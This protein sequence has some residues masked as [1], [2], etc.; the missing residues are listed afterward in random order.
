MNRS[1]PPRAPLFAMLALAFATSAQAQTPAASNDAQTIEALTRRLEALERRNGVGSYASS[2]QASGDAPAVADLDQRLR[3]LERKLELQEEAAAAKAETTPVV[4]LAADKGLSVKSE[5]GDLEVKLRGLVQADGRFFIDDA[6]A[7]N[8]GFLM[9][10]VEPMLEGSWGLLGFRLQPQLA[11]DSAT[12]NDAYLDLKFDP[13]ATLRVGKFKTPVGLEQLQASGSLAAIERGLPS[14]LVPARDYGVQLQGAFAEGTLNY[15]AGVFNGSADGR[16]AATGNPDDDFEF[17]GRLFFE[18]WKNGAGALSGLGFGIAGSS[19]EKHGSGNSFLPRYRSPGQAQFF[20]Y[21]SEVLADGDHVRWSP[22]AYWYRNAFG[23]FGEYVS[24]RQDLALAD[25]T[26]AELDN[27]AWQLTVSLVLTG[28]DASYRGVTRP[29]QPFTVDG[30]GWGA[31]EVVGRY[32]RL[33]VDDDAFPLFADP[34]SA[35]S[36]A[37]AWGLG[38]NWYLTGNLKLVANYT[39]AR[40]DGGAADGA[41]KED[42]KAF[43]TRAQFSF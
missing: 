18:P 21:R 37:T 23:L 9:R 42:E 25:G 29:N 10:R 33:D 30:A 31:F 14:E 27:R 41:D 12:L 13:R 5:S 3:I 8:D 22:Q 38:L 34:A 4:S 24:S 2:D 36:A 20:G 40:F 1:S 15:V 39:Q 32:G 7:Q 28:E 6:A 17:A 19:G 35:A 16:D 26:R 43:F 11:G